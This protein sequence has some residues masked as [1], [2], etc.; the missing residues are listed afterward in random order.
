VEHITVLAALAEFMA[1]DPEVKT[2]IVLLGVVF[3]TFH[4]W[5]CP[6]LVICQSAFLAFIAISSLPEFT[7]PAAAKLLPG[8]EA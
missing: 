3:V 8:L 1:A 4:C 5:H 7:A 2:V 6:R